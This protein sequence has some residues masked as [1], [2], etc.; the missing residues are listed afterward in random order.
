MPE[1]IHRDD[2]PD[3]PAGRF[4]WAGNQ[5]EVSWYIHTY[6]SQWLPAR[7]CSEDPG[8]VADALFDATR[9]WHVSLHFN[10]ALY[11]ASPE[12]LA[13]DRATAI[14]PSVFEAAALVMTASAEQNVFPGIPGHEP[15]LHRAA[16][17]ADQVAAAMVPI[18]SIAPGAGSYV[19]ET[20]YFEGDWQHAFWGVNYERLQQVKSRY[21]PTNFF[22]VHHGVEPIGDTVA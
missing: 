4:W 3:A 15:D 22:R 18:R 2:R 16:R 11:G 21:D 8:H 7:V 17:C 13:R 1:R 12:V 9:H 6:K 14:N 10:K 20:D 5:N 19:N